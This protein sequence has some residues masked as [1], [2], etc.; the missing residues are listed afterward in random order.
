MLQL[1]AKH[2]STL[3]VVK[4]FNVIGCMTD[5]VPVMSSGYKRRKTVVQ[6]KEEKVVEKKKKTF[7]FKLRVNLRLWSIS[8]SSV[9][10][11]CII[12]PVHHTTAGK[13]EMHI[14]KKQKQKPHNLKKCSCRNSPKITKC[15][16]ICQITH[17]FSV[18]Y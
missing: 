3:V 2:P 5:V 8:H 9:D 10:V 15:Q 17:C 18:V 14:F 1:C 16:N 12:I 6:K 11:A 4:I 7:F 13:R